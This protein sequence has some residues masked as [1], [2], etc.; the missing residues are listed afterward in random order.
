MKQTIY[1]MELWPTRIAYFEM[2]PEIAKIHNPELIRLV[3]AGCAA[4]KGLAVRELRLFDL[5]EVE[6][7]SVHW[8]VSEVRKAAAIYAGFGASAG[9]R[10]C[11]RGVQID[12]GMHINT[13]TEM[14]ESDLAVAY[15]P[16]GDPDKVG[17]P[18]SENGDEWAPT[19]V[20]EDPSRGLSDLRL[21]F[22]TRHSVNVYPRPGLMAVYP[23][24]LPHNF[25][26]YL[27]RIPFIHIVAQVRFPWPK[28]YFRS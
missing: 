5:E 27:G 18:L 28:D 6:H 10:V 2:D 3:M 17:S 19:F 23:A 26:P 9:I 1:T 8:L 20:L 12:H 13:H 21:P 11:L 4:Q 22:E 25:H 14:R 16:S 7:P 15:W 24:H